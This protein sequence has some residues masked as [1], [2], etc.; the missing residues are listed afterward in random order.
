[1]QRTPA[2][3]SGLLKAV[4]L[5]VIIGLGSGCAPSTSAKP[6]PAAIFTAAALTAYVRETSIAL[7]SPPPA[8]TE[9]PTLSE[10]E[11]TSQAAP[12]ETQP[13][14][15]ASTEAPTSVVETQPVSTSTPAPGE[16]ATPANTPETSNAGAACIPANPPQTGKVL[17]IL[18]GDTIKVMIDGKTFTVRYIGI[19]APEFIKSKD[20]YSN[21]AR[22]KNS[23]LVFAK[24]ITLYTDG[25][26]T[27]EA[28]RLLRYVKVGDTFVNLE[29]VSM[30][31]AKAVAA[32]ANNSCDAVFKSAQ[33]Q[34]S[35]SKKGL[36]SQP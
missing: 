25:L 31:Y 5:L 24:E 14:S 3:T 28:G 2:Q 20:F 22:L 1:M 19:D 12:Q 36:W 15:S 4:F 34:A 7:T 33:D 13:P 32:G 9:R 29:L 27:D 21:E 6:D 30:G 16:T 10:S 26:E 8:S 18:D 23:E 35:T 17:D 11:M